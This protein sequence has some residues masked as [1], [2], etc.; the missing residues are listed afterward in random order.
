[1]YS[2][3]SSLPNQ[4]FDL[5]FQIETETASVPLARGEDG[6]ATDGVGETRYT[7]DEGFLEISFF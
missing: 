1:M 3:V 4:I 2:C 7:L 5:V 6:A